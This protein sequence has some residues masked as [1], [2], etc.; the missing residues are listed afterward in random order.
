LTTVSSSAR[1]SYLKTARQPS[2]VRSYGCLY[3]RSTRPQRPIAVLFLVLLPKMLIVL[4]Q[5]EGDVPGRETLRS[6]SEPVALGDA[7]LAIAR[8]K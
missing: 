8:R 5:G 4:P 2:S 3:L 1:P 7:A 6:A